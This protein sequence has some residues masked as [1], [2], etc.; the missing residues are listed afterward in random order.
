MVL[1]LRTPKIVTIGLLFFKKNF[2]KF[3]YKLMDQ[4]YNTMDENRSQ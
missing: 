2:I 1:I 4:N 3:H